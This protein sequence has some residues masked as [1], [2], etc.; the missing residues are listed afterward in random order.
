VVSSAASGIPVIQ[1]PSNTGSA[2]SSS[3]PSRTE[4]EARNVRARPVRQSPDQ[5]HLE[6]IFGRNDDALSDISE[7][8][9]ANQ[10]S[11]PNQTLAQSPTPSPSLIVDKKRRR[12]LTQEAK[13]SQP[14][15]KREFP[16]PAAPRSN[17]EQESSSL[18][19]AL[20]PRSTTIESMDVRSSSTLVELDQE[21]A[22]R[23]KTNAGISAVSR[24]KSPMQDASATFETRSKR[25]LNA[26]QDSAAVIAAPVTPDRPAKRAHLEPPTK[27]GATVM[28]KK[29]AVPSR[30]RKYGRS[31]RDRS[32][33]PPNMTA[34]TTGLPASLPE[35]EFTLHAPVSG[36]PP[37]ASPPVPRRAGAED[38][39][40][41][42]KEQK[43][44]SKKRAMAV[45]AAPAAQLATDD[46]A[47]SFAEAPTLRKSASIKAAKPRDVHSPPTAKPVAESTEAESMRGQP[48]PVVIDT[49]V[50]AEKVKAKAER[51]AQARLNLR[52]AK[53]AASD[54][55][56]TAR[57]VACTP[58]D[59]EYKQEESL[60]RKPGVLEVW[61]IPRM[62]MVM[63][64]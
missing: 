58:P 9:P 30:V 19:L 38:H 21:V 55:S 46:S 40:A 6:N 49:L 18:A 3:A 57:S 1:P 47:P 29:P 53:A 35:R 62:R 60:S 14:P 20:K 33:S 36:V 41:K 12:I 4:H 24:E 50:K 23:L 22:R 7:F 34:S 39:A 28:K 13:P 59:A 26:L 16:L 8:S 52:N 27:Q 63:S 61:I 43:K 10:T 51:A 42:K 56:P 44:H 25:R 15:A 45:D 2:S 31:K 17:S 32:F 54:S 37:F 64:H 5:R 11:L 48:R